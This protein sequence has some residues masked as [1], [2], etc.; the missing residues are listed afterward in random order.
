MTK[1]FDRKT[2]IF[3]GCTKLSRNKGKY[4]GKVRY[5][6]YCEVHHR[7]KYKNDNAISEYMLDRRKIDNSKCS[8]CGWDK[9]PCDRH[10]IKHDEGYKPEN[11]L[12]LCP[13]CHRLIHLGL[14]KY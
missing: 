7:M 10:R 5:D 9:A 6:C 11:I 12:V 13:N 2:C 8:V 14:L 3:P 1:I 4:K